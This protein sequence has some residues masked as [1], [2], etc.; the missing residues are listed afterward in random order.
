MFDKINKN[1]T[2]SDTASIETNWS[3]LKSSLLLPLNETQKTNN[4]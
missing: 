2:L 4:N 1:K 3:N